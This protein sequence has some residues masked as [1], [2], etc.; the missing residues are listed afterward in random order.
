MFNF[1]KQT[2]SY[3]KNMHALLIQWPISKKMMFTT[4]MA[5]LAAVFQSA[6]GFL[7]GIGYLISPLTT[8]P[9]LLATLISLRWGTLSYLLTICL[10]FLIQPSELIIFPF[11]TG[12]LGIVLG[13]VLRTQT[14]RWLGSL[15]CGTTLFVGICIPLYGLGFPVFG[16]GI[17]SFKWSTILIIFGF[18]ILYSWLWLEFGLGIVRRLKRF[19]R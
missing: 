5:S 11:T 17:S 12:I 14:S 4:L 7:P 6:G 13:W 8:A 3:P 10:L 1:I 9:I 19:L 15:M 18:S 16:P 2:P